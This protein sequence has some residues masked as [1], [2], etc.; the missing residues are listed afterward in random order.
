MKK[1]PGGSTSPEAGAKRTVYIMADRFSPQSGG[2][3]RATFL[4]ARELSQ[5][6]HDVAILTF[7]Y[8]LDYADV[9]AGWASKSRL[10]RKVRHLNIF[11]H[12]AGE[13]L[14]SSGA[15]VVFDGA[16]RGALREVR[17]GVWERRQEGK[18]E[19]RFVTRP[20]G[21]L[22]YIDY[23]RD[24]VRR[25][26]ANYDQQERLRVETRHTEDGKTIESR[27]YRTA[28][29]RLFLEV[30]YRDGKP[31]RHRL[32]GRDGVAVDYAS[33]FAF[34]AAWVDELHRGVP[35]SV[36]VSEDRRL[37]GLLV[38]NPHS[39]DM[40]SVCAI[41][42]TH[43]A[44]PYQDVHDLATYNDSA[45]RRA[46]RFDAIVLLTDRQRSDIEEHYGTLP[47][48]V[49][50]PHAVSAPWR[51]RVPRR[52]RNIVVVTRLVP[53]KRVQDTIDAFATVAAAHPDVNLE[54]WGSGEELERLTAH[55]AS[56]GLAQRVEFKGYTA[57]P[58]DVY[59]RALF[60]VSSS[61]TEGMGLSTCE[62]LSVGTPVASYDYRYG[63]RDLIQDGVNG[64]LAEDGDVEG[65]G[66]AMARLLSS[67]ARLRRMSRASRG[68]LRTHSRKNY[69][70]AWETLLDGVGQE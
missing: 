59:S 11:E 52:R 22:G 30:G 60:S 3:T 29:G 50:I 1:N 35:G 57:K 19:S 5:S 27:T 66:Q 14:G 20:D 68:I 46:S 7:N 15:S 33:E 55:A 37:D 12:Y 21:S 8:R 67:P 16:G 24:G 61:L 13:E 25:I 56:A 49:V 34:R 70:R 40:T 45:L 10:G 63:A 48:A 64:Y 54:I 51:Y 65:L 38:Q 44:P 69:R 47:N 26:H 53:V 58:L 41:H 43:L 42:S 6:G 17:E 32:Y 62:S 4:R 9:W 2:R 23:F 28:S 18:L 36:F 39:S 31:A